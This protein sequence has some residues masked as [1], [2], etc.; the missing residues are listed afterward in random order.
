[1]TIRARTTATTSSTSRPSPIPRRA[2]ATQ[3]TTPRRTRQQHEHSDRAEHE[4]SHRVAESERGGERAD[5]DRHDVAGE[6]AEA[7]CAGSRSTSVACA[8]LD[9]RQVEVVS[10]LRARGLAYTEHELVEELDRESAAT[11]AAR[12]DDHGLPRMC[13][14][15]IAVTRAHL[16]KF[17]RNVSFSL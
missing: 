8:D 17:C 1:M 7:A 11:S 16:R 12:L 5:R 4:G 9:V 13:M 14:T 3:R 15:F 6:A 10:E 2:T